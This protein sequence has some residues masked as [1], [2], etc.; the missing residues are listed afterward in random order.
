MRFL[1]R[2][3]L[4]LSASQIRV[5]HGSRDEGGVM[6]YHVAAKSAIKAGLPKGGTGTVCT[7]QACFPSAH[8]EQLSLGEACVGHI[9]KRDVHHDSTE[10]HGRYIEPLKR[11][12]CQIQLPGQV[13]TVSL[14]V[15]EH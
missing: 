10:I 9:C 6:Q 5:L 11:R 3:F 13:V 8:A 4:K 15:R 7:L 1:H 12:P 14:W 2:S